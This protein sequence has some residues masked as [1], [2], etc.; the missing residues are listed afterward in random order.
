MWQD[1]GTIPVALEGEPEYLVSS[2]GSLYSVFELPTAPM[3]PG[4]MIIP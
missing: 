1:E 4:S 3:D 2:Q